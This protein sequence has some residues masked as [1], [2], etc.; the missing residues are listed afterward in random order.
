MKI[1]AGDAG[2]AGGL[3]RAS[4]PPARAIVTRQGRDADRRL[5]WSAAE[6]ERG[7]L[8]TRPSPW[9]SSFAPAVCIHIYTP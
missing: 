5:G 9:V 3:M 2:D 6:I 1:L 8:G 4:S 7:P